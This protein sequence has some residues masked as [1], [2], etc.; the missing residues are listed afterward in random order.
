MGLVP[1][2]KG[3]GPENG[4]F[5]SSFL[6]QLRATSKDLALDG[7]SASGAPSWFSSARCERPRTCLSA[8]FA[9]LVPVPGMLK[10]SMLKRRCGLLPAHPS[11]RW[12]RTHA[13][14]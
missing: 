6:R 1:L 13:W 7:T 14:P 11:D 12:D 3:A 2:E 10:G 8:L 5:F 9:D 4:S